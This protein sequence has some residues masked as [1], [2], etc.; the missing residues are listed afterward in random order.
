MAAFK[1]GDRVYLTIRKGTFI[2]T[3]K[4]VSTNKGVVAPYVVEYRDENN[5]LRTHNATK[6][7]IEVR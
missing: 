3:I 4:H 6:A 2:G 5:N 7:E 1:A